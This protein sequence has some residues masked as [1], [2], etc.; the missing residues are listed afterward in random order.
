MHK[1]QDICGVS[2]SSIGNGLFP[3]LHL[4]HPSHTNKCMSLCTMPTSTPFIMLWSMY[5]L[6]VLKCHNFLCQ[7]SKQCDCLKICQIIHF[8]SIHHIHVQLLQIGLGWSNGQHLTIACLHHTSQQIGF[9]LLKMNIVIE[10]KF[11]RKLGTWRM[12]YFLMLCTWLLTHV[13]TSVDLLPTT[14]TMPLLPIN[15][16]QLKMGLYVVQKC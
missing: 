6:F 1:H 13:S 2:S 9:K 8:G 10:S 3:C 5:T 14:S 12:S 4:T 7:S 15:T 16:L 11:I